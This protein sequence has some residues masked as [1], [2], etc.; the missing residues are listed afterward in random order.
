[1]RR[2][3]PAALLVAAC[4]QTADAPATTILADDTT[5]ADEPTTTTDEPTPTTSTAPEP[6]STT[7]TTTTDAASTTAA[8]TTDASTSGSSSTTDLAGCGNGV[9]DPGEQCDD[10]PDN[11]DNGSCTLHCKQAVCGDG[12][13]GPTEQCDDGPMNKENTYGVC[14][15]YC[16][17]GPH[18]GD[19]IQ[20][21]EEECD[22]GMKN[23]TGENAS[24][25]GVPCTQ[26]CH[27]QAALV[28][29]SHDTFTVTELGG[30]V[31][32]IDKLCQKLA[33]DADLWNSTN[34]KAWISNK[35]GGVNGGFQ[36]DPDELPYALLNGKLIAT[37]RNA[38]F[39]QGPLTGITRTE[40]GATLLDA[41]TWT[42][43]NQDGTLH[44]VD[45]NCDN[46]QSESPAFKARVG[47]SGVD[48][49]DPAAF[50]E[51]KTNHH[52]TSYA[53]YGCHEEF[54][55]YCFED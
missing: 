46:W 15:P 11:S 40:K 13:V 8:S 38:L 19:G 34:F 37:S 50:A 54:H 22:L 23:G 27:Y 9:D 7:T 43:T 14:G 25:D 26:S 16:T 36:S 32:N 48:E 41:W 35:Y 30:A 21:P 4:T 29:L 49:N 20:Q 31:Y 42:N 12:L 45:L 51:W 28:F 3:L 39:Q 44:H 24:I 55:L 5:T 33:A 6:D 52:W 10:G 17:F 1:M 47:R 53:T 18:C 2:H